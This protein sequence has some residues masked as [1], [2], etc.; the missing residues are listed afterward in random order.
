MAVGQVTLS[1]EEAEA[2]FFFCSTVVQQNMRDFFHDANNI[3]GVLAG[4]SEMILNDPRGGSSSRLQALQESANRFKSLANP[5]ITILRGSPHRA[6]PD[7]LN[8]P[9]FFQNV[10]MLREGALRK[11]DTKLVTTVG[12]IP[13]G[14]DTDLPSLAAIILAVLLEMQHSLTKAPQAPHIF[15]MVVSGEPNELTIR[16][17]VSHPLV[18][19]EKLEDWGRGWVMSRVHP[20][21]IE[22]FQIALRRLRADFVRES[23]LCWILRCASLPMYMER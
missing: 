4:Y 3:I 2:W 14:F 16:W 11:R 10:S 1:Q 5:L 21:F 17:E 19:P 23:T 20:L 15:D 18:L 22:G 8:A 7:V 9:Q 6:I 13:M 12:H